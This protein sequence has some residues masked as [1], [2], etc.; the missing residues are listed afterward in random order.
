MVRNAGSTGVQADAICLLQPRHELTNR[1][2]TRG[3]D[4]RPADA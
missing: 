2:A 3:D 4:G 1:E